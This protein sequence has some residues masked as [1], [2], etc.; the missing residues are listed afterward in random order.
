M[1]CTTFYNSSTMSNGGVGMAYTTQQAVDTLNGY[2]GISEERKEYIE[3]TKNRG[4]VLT[5]DSGEKIVI[6]IYPL[7][8]KQDN[9]K[10]YFDTR[11]SGAYERGVTWKYALKH[12]MKYFCFGVNNQ[13]DKFNDYV[14][15]LECNETSC[16]CSSW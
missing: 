11:D 6:F 15:S 10:N 14:F 2:L 3:D 5:L 8:H 16:P 4:F 9:T 1:Q 13:V 7:V 12:G